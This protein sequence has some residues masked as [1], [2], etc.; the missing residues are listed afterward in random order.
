MIAS[1]MLLLTRVI[2]RLAAPWVA[3]GD[4]NNAPEHFAETKWRGERGR[5]ANPRQDGDGI[6]LDPNAHSELD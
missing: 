1:H 2:K 5:R 3:L 6:G 4:W